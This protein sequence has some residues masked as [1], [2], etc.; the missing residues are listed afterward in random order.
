MPE[1]RTLRVRM[2]IALYE[3]AVAIC[4]KN[5]ATLSETTRE[6]WRALAKDEERH[7]ATYGSLDTTSQ[8]SP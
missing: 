4:T 7:E 5:N 2:P 6:M 3:K 8:E 1:S